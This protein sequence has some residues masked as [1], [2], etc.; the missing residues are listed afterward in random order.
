MRSVVGVKTGVAATNGVPDRGPGLVLKKTQ[1]L[2]RGELEGVVES[3]EALSLRWK[4][5]V[6]LRLESGVR[7]DELAME[8]VRS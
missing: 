1:V 6:V 8:E 7:T 2:T 5:E 4:R 3:E